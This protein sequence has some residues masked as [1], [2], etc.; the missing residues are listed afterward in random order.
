MEDVVAMSCENCRDCVSQESFNQ[1]KQVVRDLVK[2]LVHLSQTVDDISLEENPLW[3]GQ[4]YVYVPRI[5]IEKTLKNERG[6][7]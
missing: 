4:K 3:P 6:L 2:D 5:Y 7:W 1:L